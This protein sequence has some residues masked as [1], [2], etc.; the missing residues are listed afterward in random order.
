[1]RA[2]IISY[3]FEPAPHPRALRWGRLSR[4]LCEQGWHVDVITVRDP[5]RRITDDKLR[6]FEAGWSFRNW[7]AA[8]RSGRITQNRRPRSGRHRGLSWLYRA[9]WRRLYWP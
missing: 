6:V 2:L 4:W 7:Y 9:T 8:Y 5:E 3:F 1:M